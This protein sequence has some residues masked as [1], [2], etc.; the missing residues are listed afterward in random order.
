MELCNHTWL[1]TGL[2]RQCHACARV[3]IMR[4]TL[5]E[6]LDKRAISAMQARELLGGR[7]VHGPTN[8]QQRR[9]TVTQYCSWTNRAASTHGLPPLDVQNMA[10]K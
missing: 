7:H 10:N 6:S 4:I 2:R 9:R 8:G 3:H 1:Q 5:H